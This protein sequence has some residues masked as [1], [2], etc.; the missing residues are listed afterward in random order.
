M[1]DTDFDQ[2]LVSAAFAL[3][4]QDGWRKVS[5][6]AAALHAGLDLGTARARF[7]SCGAILRKFG[8]MADCHALQGA[9]AEGAVRDRLFDM[10]LRR[11]D[12]LQLH[13]DGVVALLRFLPAAPSLGLCLAHATVESMGWLLEA[14]GVSA[15][16]LRGEV[17][18]RGLALVWG[19]GARAWLRDETPDLA[20][21]MAAVDKALAQADALA[22]RFAAP[23]PAAYAT[24]LPST[25]AASGVA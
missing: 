5:P 17:R 10:L 23:P 3:G 25:Q 8:E 19:Y 18:K 9:L 7:G 21:T 13:R 14:A 22:V 15:T 2:A 12:F 6:A 20:A 1:T 16:G 4:A 24:D 11:F